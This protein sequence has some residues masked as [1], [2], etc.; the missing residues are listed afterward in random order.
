MNDKSV[1]DFYK[2]VIFSLTIPEQL[3]LMTLLYERIKD[4]TDSTSQEYHESVAYVE[5]IRQDGMYHPNGRLKTPEEFLQE[6][7]AENVD[8]STR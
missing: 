6:A 7:L 5:K 2:E 1:T 4:F 8:E 3:E